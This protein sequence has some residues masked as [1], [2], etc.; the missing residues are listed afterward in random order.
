MKKDELVELVLSHAGG[1]AAPTAKGAA[2]R[3]GGGPP[4]KSALKERIQALKKD[5][6]EALAGDDHDRARR[7]NREIHRCKRVL[8]KMA[9]KTK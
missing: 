8:R 3:K 4:D 9:R 2:G 7:C 1:G 6:R 5:K